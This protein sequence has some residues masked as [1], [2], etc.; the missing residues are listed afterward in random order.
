M[1]AYTFREL[2]DR[3][4]NLLES[5]SVLESSLSLYMYALKNCHHFFLFRPLSVL[6]LLFEAQ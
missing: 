5:F 1:L 4:A 2:L 6:Y 3:Y